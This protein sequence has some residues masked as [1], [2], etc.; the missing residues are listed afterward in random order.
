MVTGHAVEA[1]TEP[2]KGFAYVYQADT[3][4][5]KKTPIQWRGVKDNMIIISEGLSPGDIVAT[6]GVSFLSDGMK[7]KLMADAKK[8][9]PET[10]VVE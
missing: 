3:S 4:T 7:V 1:T 10:L 8:A 2:N 6:A 9:K 5:V